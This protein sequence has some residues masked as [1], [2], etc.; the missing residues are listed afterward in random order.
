[1]GENKNIWVFVEFK[2]GVVRGVSLELIGK[3]KELAEKTQEKV[4]AV[5]IGNNDAGKA[6]DSYTF[7]RYNIYAIVF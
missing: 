2:K 6:G 7:C 3:A 4:C 1:M 5:L